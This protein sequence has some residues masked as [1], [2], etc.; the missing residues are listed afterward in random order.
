MFSRHRRQWREGEV[1]MTEG[2]QQ[3]KG[4]CIAPEGEGHQ[5]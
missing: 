1:D 5:C 4:D 2:E 3:V